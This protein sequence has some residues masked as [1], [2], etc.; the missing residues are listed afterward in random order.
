MKVCFAA[1][2]LVPNA[3]LGGHA[4]VSLNWVHG[5][6]QAGA[7]VVLLDDCCREAGGSEAVADL[8]RF[9]RSLQRLGI[10]VEVSL[11][12]DEAARERMAGVESEI[13]ART[14]P[15]DEVCAESDLFLNCNYALGPEVI[16]RFERSALL[17]ID[18]GLLQL[19]VDSGHMEL[20]AHDLYFSIGETVGRP[21]ARFSDCGREWHYT[22]PAVSLS[23]WPVA[24]VEPDAAYTTVTNWWGE[25]EIHDG[26]SFNNEKREAFLEYLELPSRVDVPLEL[27]IYHEDGNAS[28][29]PM[30]REHGWRARPAYEVSATPE[31]YHDYVRASRGE[32]SCAKASCYRLRN[33][34]ISDRTIAYLASGKP[35]VVQYTGA[36]RFL[37]DSAGLHRFR[38]LDEA[39]RMLAHVEADYDTQCGLSR[40]LAERHFDAKKVAGALLDR[41]MEKAHG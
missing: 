18:P 5:L 6:Q 2:Y 29:I 37:P 11:L 13:A 41:A 3:T 40:Q 20:H 16:E 4:W 33:A 1:R 30:L 14:R 8:D 22:P 32:F 10:D 39:A 12:L 26:E 36:S 35:C 38:T 23:A 7:E 15:F 27:A 34:W 9:Q 25:Y 21:E 17:D 28:E 24:R 31:A 19:W